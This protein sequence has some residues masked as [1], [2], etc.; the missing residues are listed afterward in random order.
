MYA[1][2]NK[3]DSTRVLI[4]RSIVTTK[5]KCVTGQRLTQFRPLHFMVCDFC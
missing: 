4:L 3:G 2:N 1:R 5:T